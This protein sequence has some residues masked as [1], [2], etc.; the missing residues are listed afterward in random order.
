[1][2]SLYASEWRRLLEGFDAAP[3]AALARVAQSHNEILAQ[4][5]YRVMLKDET[6]AG[7]LSH[8]QVHTRLMAS[9]RQWIL[10]VLGAQPEDDLEALV[11][12]QIKIGE[13]HA[14]ID[15]PVHVV[16]RGAR[17]L[18]EGLRA[19]LQQEAVAGQYQVMQLAST[20][21]DH[22][23][24]LMSQGYVV[25]RDSNSRTQEA[26]RLFTMTQNLATVREQR[27][28][29][30][31]DWENQCLYLHAMGAQS[32]P[33]SNLTTSDF[34]LWF[35]HKGVDVFHGA[36]ACQS[37]L[38]AMERIDTELLP[39]LMKA[40]GPAVAAPLLQLREQARHIAM[41]LEGLFAQNTELDAGR[42]VLT[43]LLN[44]KFLPVVLTKEV[45]YARQS[46]SVFSI[47]SVDLDHFKKVNDQY[48]HEGGDMVLQQ[49]ATVLGNNI[50]GGD[51]L[52]RLGG[53]EFLLVLVDTS[54]QGAA[55]VAE[56]L[57]A[58]IEREVF[59][60]PQNQ[61]CSIT[62]SAGIATFDGHPD[63]QRILR[64]SDEALYRAKAAGRNRV[65]IA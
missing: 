48:G 22:A 25:S 32:Q 18:K 20:V 24:E 54:S 39:A 40:K 46:A 36:P 55:S 35:R 63:Y 17:S 10:Q 45:Q 4:H 31:L 42:D 19:V 50:R 1:M 29:E 6:A 56:K 38:E 47:V 9:M 16:L 41:S 57:R 44:R 60:L 62:I 2:F 37:I 12:H 59:H 49:A 27:R 13:V 28:A 34:G 51:Y 21:I 8:E 23:M 58:Q 11:A 33:L 52:F 64:Q 30:L 3:R 65:V 61:H 14:R 7:M 43:Q 53:E 5:F 26:Y 15:V